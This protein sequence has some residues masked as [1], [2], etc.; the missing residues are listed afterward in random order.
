MIVACTSGIGKE[1][2]SGCTLKVE[3]TGFAHRLN[4]GVIWKRGT[5]DDSK[6]SGLS[7][8]KEEQDRGRHKFGMGWSS[9]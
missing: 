5:I 7:K 3:P 9:V 1:S 8:Q 2:N 4:V 6:V